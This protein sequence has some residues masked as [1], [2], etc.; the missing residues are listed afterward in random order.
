MFWFS[1]FFGKSEPEVP[2]DSRYRPKPPP[3]PPDVGSSVQTVTKEYIQKSSSYYLKKYI[4][5]RDEKYWEL[6]KRSKAL[7]TRRH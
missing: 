5:T 4:E 7:E 1:K 6:F 3:G 2:V